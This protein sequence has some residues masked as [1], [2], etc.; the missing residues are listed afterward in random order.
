MGFLCQLARFAMSFPLAFWLRV[1][2]FRHGLK[3]LFLSVTPACD[4]GLLYKEDRC[5]SFMRTPGSFGLQ[6]TV[7]LLT[8]AS[9]PA[10][11]RV[12]L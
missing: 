9:H 2:D 1:P 8:I 4:S 11:Q 3:T 6:P 5:L 10:F 12:I 7:G